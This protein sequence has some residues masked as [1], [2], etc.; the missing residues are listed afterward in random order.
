MA[1]L[2]ISIGREFGSGGHIIA[3]I[4]AKKYN[5]PLYDNNIIT[6]IANEKGIDRNELEKYN[7]RPKNKL[8][9]RTVR[10]Y[11]NSLEENVAEMQFNFLRKKAQKGESFVVVGRCSESI[12]KGNPALISIFI[13]AD[14]DCKI[15]RIM[16]LKTLSKEKAES[17]LIK[18]DKIR[19][20]YHNDHSEIKWG[21]SRGYDLCLNSSRLGID[22]TAEIIEK[23]ISTRFPE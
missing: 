21:D 2:I 17:L 4:L 14:L 3:E 11:N 23:Y 20:S 16:K 18:T 15:E 12:L 7:E 9:S 13:L 22:K 5:L 8:M 10:G 6:E 19:K 1:Q